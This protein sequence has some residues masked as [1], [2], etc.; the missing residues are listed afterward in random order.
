MNNKICQVYALL[1]AETID[2]LFRKLIN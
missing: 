1:A 2:L